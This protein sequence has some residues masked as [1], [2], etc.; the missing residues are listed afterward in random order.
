MNLAHVSTRGTPPGAGLSRSQKDTG[1]RGGSPSR[2]GSVWLWFVVSA[3]DLGLSPDGP[4]PADGGWGWVLIVRLLRP[5]ERQLPEQ[6][7]LQETL[8]SLLQQ[9]V[10]LNRR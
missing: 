5:R 10:K 7:Q 2:R 9:T 6:R 1:P 8:A 4:V 3:P